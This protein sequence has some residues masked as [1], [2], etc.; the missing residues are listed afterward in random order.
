MSISSDLGSLSAWATE[1][2]SPLRWLAAAAFLVTAS[3]VFH[4]ANG[5]AAP[6]RGDL[7]RSLATALI[8]L[9]AFRLWDDLCDRDRDRTAHPERVLARAG[10]T[11]PFV[12]TLVVAHLV[13][14]F[15]L[16][17]IA[18]ARAGAYL[19]L[20]AVYGIHYATRDPEPGVA[21]AHVGLVKYAVFVLLVRPPGVRIDGGLLLAAAL[22]YLCFAVHELDHDV[23]LRGRPASL[24]FVFDALALSVVAWAMIGHLDGAPSRAVQALLTFMT[25]GWI[26]RRLVRFGAPKTR[27]LATHGVFIIGFIDT[28]H[29]AL[30]AGG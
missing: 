6:D 7:V 16:G 18:P 15:A 22:V 28:L 14:A 26:G 27:S 9:L 24:A 29:F 5:P 11:M 3:R 8:M 13:N 4:P 10:R 21:A 20:V 17:C 12:V 23:K 19:A 1:R 25:V 2:F 30:S